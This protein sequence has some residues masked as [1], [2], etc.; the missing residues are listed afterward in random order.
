MSYSLQDLSA[1]MKEL[2]GG[3]VMQGVDG[4]LQQG[5]SA[6][7]VVEALQKGMTEVGDLF[8]K[9]EYF[10]S[11]L[12]VAGEILKQAM[13]VLEPRLAGGGGGQ[14]KGTVVIGTVKDDIHDLGKNIV[15][16]LLKGSGYNVIDLGVDV[17]KEKFVEAIKDSGA[18]LAG[19]SVLLTACQENLKDTI[20][21]IREAGLTDVK[22]VIGGNYI[23]DRVMQYSGA[24]FYGDRADVAVKVAN[25]V[26]AN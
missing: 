13:E 26:Y 8:S 23:D 6:L 25:Q 9:G 17:P 18:K 11:E 1:Q 20:T 19:I 14:S 3:K 4:L 16:T 22:I 10:L 12:I 21:A 2:D 24:D 7:E 5:V 15:V